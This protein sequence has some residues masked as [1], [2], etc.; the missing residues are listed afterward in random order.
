MLPSDLVALWRTTA[1]AAANATIASLP[2]IGSITVN[3]A[4]YRELRQQ[5]GTG[6]DLTVRDRRSAVST[7]NADP[8]VVSLQGVTIVDGGPSAATSL[9]LA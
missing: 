7:F 3:S 9:T 5:I 4:N 1:G 2:A 6:R 8:N